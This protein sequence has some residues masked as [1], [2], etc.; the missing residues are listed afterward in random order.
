MFHTQP[1]ARRVVAPT[2]SVALAAF[3]ATE[4]SEE[5]AR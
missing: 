2:C 1:M 5:V 3:V 4:A